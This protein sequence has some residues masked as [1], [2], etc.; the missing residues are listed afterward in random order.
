MAIREQ[1]GAAPSRPRTR[2]PRALSD[3]PGPPRAP[4]NS[5]PSRPQERARA[6]EPDRPNGIYTVG[7][8]KVGDFRRPN[9]IYTVG[10]VGLSGSGALLGPAR[11]RV[12]GRSGRSWPVA[13]DSGRLWVASTVGCSGRLR[14]SRG[15][16]QARHRTPNDPKLRRNVRTQ[17][18]SFLAHSLRTSCALPP[19]ARQL[20][21]RSPG[22]GATAPAKS[23]RPARE[24]KPPPKSRSPRPGAEAPPRCPLYL[25][26]PTMEVLQPPPPS[27][28]TI[29]VLYWFTSL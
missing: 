14:A 2:P 8:P 18:R 13:E 15:A 17:A 20:E 4:A 28:S 7:S 6:R 23:R 29:M 19:S 24:P 16:A 11:C 22:Q 3:R 27:H 1:P 12:L 9:G 25:Q 5:A 26:F 21:R 10:P